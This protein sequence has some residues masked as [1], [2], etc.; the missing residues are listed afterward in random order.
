M[1]DFYYSQ[2]TSIGEGSHAQRCTFLGA[3]FSDSV[4]FITKTTLGVWVS[5]FL[6]GH[7][8]VGSNDDQVARLHQVGGGA[9]DAD[10]ARTGTARNHVGGEAGPV[11]HIVDVDFL[12]LH[13]SCG[14][15]EQRIQCD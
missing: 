2:G 15:D 9:V 7:P 5:V 12:V 10:F 3:A 13:E 6:G 11:S 4:A 14:F 1:T 8:A